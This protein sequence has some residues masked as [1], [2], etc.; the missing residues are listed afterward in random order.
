[1]ERSEPT[2]SKST[3]CRSRPRSHCFWM[4]PSIADSLSIRNGNSSM[5]MMIGDSADA[6]V[7]AIVSAA[8]HAPTGPAWAICPPGVSRSATCSPKMRSSSSLDCLEAV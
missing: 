6:P 3:G 8:S 2:S 5:T 1:M 4:I 7:A